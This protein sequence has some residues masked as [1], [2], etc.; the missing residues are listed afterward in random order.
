[1]GASEKTIALVER[2]RKE[3]LDITVDQYPYDRSSTILGHLVPSWVLADGEHAIRER[4]SSPATRARIAA[5]MREQLDSL[6]HKDYSWAMVGFSRV[7][8]AVNGKT[9]TEVNAMR[10]GKPGVEGE[11]NTILDMLAAEPSGTNMIY[12]KMGMVD[13]DRIIQYPQT[14]IASDGWVIELNSGAPHPRSYGTNS[15]V[16]AEF[17]RSRHV[18]TL[19]DAIRKMTDLPARKFALRDRGRISPGYAADLVLFDPN[20]IQDHATFV[21]PHQYSTGFE[22]VIVNGRIEVENDKVTGVRAGQVL[23]KK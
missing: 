3:G 7:N 21:K 12:H 8:P 9:I 18:I 10:S 17:V 23:R 16:L 1:M 5:E 22:L 11:I 19:E 6:G 13:V 15:R 20:T 2:Y 14:A 4:L